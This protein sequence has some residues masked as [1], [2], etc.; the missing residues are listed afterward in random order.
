M[1]G[2]VRLCVL[3]RLCTLCRARF[4]LAAQGGAP[5]RSPNGQTLASAAGKARPCVNAGTREQKA[6]STLDNLLLQPAAITNTT[7]PPLPRG[8]RHGNSR[9]VL[10]P[11]NGHV[12]AGTGNKAHA[13]C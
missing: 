13:A 7:T 6:P 10:I 9:R 2:Y 8:V 4:L 12:S 5:G 11:H 3:V 1:S